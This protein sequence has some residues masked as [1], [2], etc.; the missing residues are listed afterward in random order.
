MGLLIVTQRPSDVS[1]TILSQCNNFIVMRVAND[2]D[3][4]MI[5]R[6][7]PETVAGVKGVLPVLDIGEAVVIGDALMLTSRVKFDTPRV[8]PSSATQRYWSMWSQTPSSSD[9]I[10]AGVEA[11]RNQ[12]RVSS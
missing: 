6:L 1:R 8:K 5:E 4:A 11:L 2:E 9:A 12:L 10:K 3:Q 7:A